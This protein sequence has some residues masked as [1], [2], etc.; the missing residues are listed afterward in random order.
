MSYKYLDTTIGRLKI[1]EYDEEPAYIGKNYEY[2]GSTTVPVM[3]VTAPEHTY[4]YYQYYSYGTWASVYDEN[5]TAVGGDSHAGAGCMG[6]YAVKTVAN[7]NSA[8]LYYF[9]SPDSIQDIIAGNVPSERIYAYSYTTISLEDV[10]VG[11][12]WDESPSDNPE[13]D[14]MNEAARGGAFAD[15]EDFRTN[16]PLY[17]DSLAPIPDSIDPYNY[18]EVAQTYSVGMFT[19]YAM[20]DNDVAALGRALWSD[21]NNNWLSRVS[22]IFNGRVDPNVTGILSF[23]RLPTYVNEGAAVDVHLYGQ[24][25]GSDTDRVIGTHFTRYRS[26][27]CGTGITIK[28]SWG[29]SKDYLNTA[30]SIYLPYVGIKEL[31]TQ[32]IIGKTLHLV[33]RLDCWTGDMLYI[34]FS[35]GDEYFPQSTPIYQFECNV[36][37]NLFA[38]TGND[39]PQRDAMLSIAGSFVGAGLTTA[40]LMSIPASGVIGSAAGLAA[41]STIA[42]TDI[43]AID[44]LHQ[45]QQ[46]GYLTGQSGSISGSIG[47]MGIQDAFFIISRSVPVY[48]NGW[49]KKIGAPRFQTYKVSQL[50]GFTKFKEIRLSGLAGASVDDIARLESELIQEGIIL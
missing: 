3:V 48:P 2:P 18:D 12:E 6:A 25:L 28:E 13:E 41:I 33:C 9:T 14:P 4:S 5:G 32:H 10:P 38:S 1:S 44:T 15:L 20:T 36:A 31:N 24:K 40:A 34:L 43:K 29:S 42:N 7:P 35:E 8:Y 46:Q 16:N 26:W 45:A 11:E 37:Q 39:K 27:Q 22:A 17:W 23:F 47:N 30:V 19:P 49:R 21:V 50:S